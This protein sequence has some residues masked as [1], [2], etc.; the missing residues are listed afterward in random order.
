MGEQIQ[1]NPDEGPPSGGSNPLD[2]SG[3]LSQ[4]SADF[5]GRLNDLRANYNFSDAEIAGLVATHYRF[6][7]LREQGESNKIEK[8]L[9]FVLWMREHR[10]IYTEDN[11]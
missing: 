8:R 9:N 3:Q 7:Q 4:Q 2:I 10:G 6:Q 5:L 1:P 11:T